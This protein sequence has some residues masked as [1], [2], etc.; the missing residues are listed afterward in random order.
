MYVKEAHGVTYLLEDIKAL[1][2]R[3]NK[4][5]KKKQIGCLDVSVV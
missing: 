1:L 2:K 4:V 5:I 3:Q